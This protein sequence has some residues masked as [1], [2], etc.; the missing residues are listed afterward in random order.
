MGKY[1]ISETDNDLIGKIKEN[2]KPSLYFLS[3][4]IKKCLK[5]T[6]TLYMTQT[7]KNHS[8]EWFWVGTKV[9]PACP[10]LFSDSASKSL[11]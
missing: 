2:L 3:V 11:I 8:E 5:Q 7:K 9:Y 1:Q 6:L 10:V 4:E